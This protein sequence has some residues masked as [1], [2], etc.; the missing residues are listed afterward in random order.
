MLKCNRMPRLIQLNT[1]LGVGGGR[2]PPMQPDK[3][4][5]KRSKIFATDCS[6]VEQSHYEMENLT[7]SLDT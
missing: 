1:A 5:I 6:Y 4:N 7:N 2:R 3:E